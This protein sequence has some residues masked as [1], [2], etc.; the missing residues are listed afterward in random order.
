MTESSAAHLPPLDMLCQAMIDAVYLLDPVTSK[1]LWCNRA[2][3][4]TLGLDASEV[5]NHSVLSLQKDVTGLPQWSDIATVIRSVP[6]YTFVGRHRH[7]DGGEI[8]V[9]VITTRLLHHEREYF[10]SVARD[11]S[12]RTALDQDL[13]Q[14]DHQLWFALNEA[15]DGMWDWNVPRGDVYFSPQLK[16][17]LGYGPDEMEPRVESW[18]ENIHPE[19]RER[20]L[21]VL[22]RH[23][24]GRL[25]RYEAEYRLRNRNGHYIWVHDR[26]KV[27]QWDPQ[28]RPLRAVGMVQNIADRKL[29]EM[30]LESLAHIDDLTGLPNRRAGMAQLEQQLA[31]ASRMQQPLC[32][33][34]LDIDHFKRI[35]DRHGHARGDDVLQRVASVIRNTLRRSDYSF[36]MGGEEFVLILPG[37][38]RADCREVARKLH[39]SLA[40]IDW[41]GTLG[42]EPVT[43]SIGMACHPEEHSLPDRLLAEADLAVYRA[44]EEGR[45]RTCFAYADEDP[46]ARSHGLAE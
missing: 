27:C 19:D 5:L 45:N 20:V 29:L 13:Q 44:K 34:I 12:K 7:Q 6:N 3:Y 1:I 25:M 22:N 26:G 37:A 8:P 10:L 41:I 42:V 9:E 2:A 43:F 17:M 40:A 30:R 21:A 23:L 35:N 11:I 46:P 38:N 36:R 39:E 4:E 15:M 31:L 18:S 14:R 33:G 24:Q 16:R 28:G 32:L